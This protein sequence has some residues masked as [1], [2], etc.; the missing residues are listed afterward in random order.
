VAGVLVGAVSHL[1]WDSWTHHDGWFVLVLPALRTTVLNAGDAS[2]WLY[3]VLQHVSSAGGILLLA[4]AYSRW[5]RRATPT[6][7]PHGPPA[8]P[9]IKAAVG[10]GIGCVSLLAGLSHACV[11]IPS[12][13]TIAFIAQSSVT[14]V[15][16]FFGA[17]VLYSL[18][19]VW[20]LRGS[21]RLVDE[22]DIR[23][24]AD[25]TEPPTRAAS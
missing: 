19:W 17:W 2:L 8:H 3:D 4:V 25:T 10:T 11:N 1:V 9:L 12:G 14:T 13:R 24:E 16:A 23:M 20:R 15:S 21:G 6:T 7:I 22:S 18:I 5:Y